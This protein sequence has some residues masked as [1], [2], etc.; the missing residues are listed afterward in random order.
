MTVVQLGAP[1]VYPAPVA[2]GP[3]PGQ[4]IRLD[5]AGIVGIAPRGPVNEPVAVQTWAEYVRRFGAQAPG[6]PGRL[7][8][9]VAAFFRQGGARAWIVRVAPRAVDDSAVTVL[10]FGP[11]LTFGGGPVRLAARDEGSWGN[12]LTVR[13]DLVVTGR[14]PVAAAGVSTP[15]AGVAVPVGSLLRIGANPV[16]RWVTGHD[17]VLTLD[18]P[19][20]AEAS[21]AEVIT[22]S[23]T[24]SSAD[25]DGPP[26]ERHDGLGLSP[27]HPRWMATI[28]TEQSLVVRPAGTWA[29]RLEP[30]TP[31]LSP[32]LTGVEAAGR[33]RYEQITGG[34]FFDVVSA[35]GYPPPEPDP[36]DPPAVRYGVDALDEL[37]GELGLLVVPDLLHAPDPAP[38]PTVEPTSPTHRYRPRFAPCTPPDPATPEPPPPARP[39]VLDDD[40]EILA[41]QRGLVARTGPDR[42]AIALLDVPPHLRG[43]QILTWR[44]AFD[45]DRVAAYHPWLRLVRADGTS[46]IAPPSPFAAGIIAARELRSGVATGP[47]NELAA[48]AIGV[49]DVLTEELHGVLHRAG[50][51]AFR[52]ERDGVRLL[53]ARTLSS[54][55]A[56]RQLSVRRLMTWVRLAVTRR[57]ETALFDA[58]TTALRTS[59]RLQVTA[60]LAELF[61]AGALNGT[62]EAEAFFVHCDDT[63]NPLRT[64]EQGRLVI[65][66][67][68]NPSEPIEYILLRFALAANGSVSVAEEAR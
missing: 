51:N 59:L 9:A 53:G 27:E 22:A 34:S 55:P 63:L 33:D 66:V 24:V 38:A 3:P 42:P 15:P 30:A 13:A 67:G 11:E 32:A 5:V 62:S 47:A 12:R 52:P 50:I 17:P 49:A 7:A 20:P 39:G 45:S 56:Y 43:T 48:D 64:V 18:R 28:L 10:R 35:G 37:A 23:V 16:L 57:L 54:D 25:P 8:D 36:D 46:V 1:G 40:T 68:V 41:R 6:Y 31:D 4:P 60:L 44:A 21:T 26:T 29:G 61:R 2:S 58:N 19:I 14:F 65:E